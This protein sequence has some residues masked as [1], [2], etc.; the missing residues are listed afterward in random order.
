M[1]RRP[2]GHGPT[3]IMRPKDASKAPASLAW[4]LTVAKSTSAPGQ[5]RCLL[6]VHAHP[7][8]E[9]EFGAPT[10]ARYHHEGVRTVLVCCTD[11]G[12][13]RVRNPDFGPVGD[14]TDMVQI[15]RRELKE[16]VA[17][18]G[19]DVV[20]RLDYPDSGSV[21]LKERSPTCFAR[22]PLEG[23]V[24][25][26]VKV[27]RRERPQVIVAYPDDQRVYPHP[28]HWRAHEVALAAFD[29]AGSS[30]AY[31]TAGSPWQP[32][33]LY[34]TLTSRERRHVINDKYTALGLE[35]PFTAR[36]GAGL[37][38]RGD[39]DLAPSEERVTTRVDVAAFAHK[40][41]EAMRVHRCQITPALA[42][43]L[44]VPPD[45]IPDIYGVDEYILARD[46]TPPDE[47]AVQD[48]ADLFAR[49][50]PVGRKL[51]P[52]PVQAGRRS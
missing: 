24:S 35:A 49:V 19:Y 46:L 42:E 33:K 44:S 39:P 22:I 50:R 17:I 25:R 28:D 11:G 8:D 38:G 7:D 37:Q 32:L 21:N 14:Q 26:L 2:N 6:T 31:A 20:V 18:V 48:E 29:A 5:S 41:V 40:W 10:V 43:T 45:A 16:A 4:S 27:I 15:R 30:E 23:P 1:R 52:R 3:T 34:Y 12:S 47:G 36:E 9:S 51:A 13:G